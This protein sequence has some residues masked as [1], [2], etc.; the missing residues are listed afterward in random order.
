MELSDFQVETQASSDEQLDY[1]VR[2][3]LEDVDYEVTGIRW[4]HHERLVLIEAQ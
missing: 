4:D 1:V 3:R 2:V